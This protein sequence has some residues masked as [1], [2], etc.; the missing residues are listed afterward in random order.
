MNQTTQRVMLVGCNTAAML[1]TS[2]RSE[3]QR[4]RATDSLKAE[5]Q[6]DLESSRLVFSG[7][8][9]WPLSHSDRLSS[10][11]FVTGQSQQLVSHEA[12]LI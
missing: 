10:S 4:R 6:M 8:Y 9:I 7:R 11:R 3:H 1:C 5:K 2:V 12:G